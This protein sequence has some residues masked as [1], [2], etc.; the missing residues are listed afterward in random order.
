M[1]MVIEVIEVVSITH[2]LLEA[3][4]EQDIVEIVG[5]IIMVIINVLHLHRLDLGLRHAVADAQLKIM[6]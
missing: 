2:R 4:L 5:S 6:L 3:H 1:A